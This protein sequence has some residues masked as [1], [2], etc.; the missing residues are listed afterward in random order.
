VKELVGSCCVTQG[1]QLDALGQPRGVG[2]EGGGSGGKG[3][4]YTWLLYIV[5]QQKPTQ[6]CKAII[7]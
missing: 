4:I 2:C 7:L 3:S 6:P 5:V 1:A